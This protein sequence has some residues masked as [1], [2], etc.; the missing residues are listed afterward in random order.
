MNKGIDELSSKGRKCEGGRTG[1]LEEG[2]KERGKKGGRKR[3][4]E[5]GKIG[6]KGGMEE[7]KKRRRKI[8]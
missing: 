3:W 5:G 8:S 7:E 4:R 1:E 2:R 6:C